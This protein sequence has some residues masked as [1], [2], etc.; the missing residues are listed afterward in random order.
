MTADLSILNHIRIATPCSA[1]WE[2]MAGDERTRFCGSC[3]KH[4]Y[5]IASMTAEEAASLIHAREGNL[6]ARLFQRADGTVMTSDCP[7]G[8]RGIWSGTQ[9]LAAAISVVAVLFMGAFLLPNVVRGDPDGGSGRGPI[10]QRATALW[11]DLLVWMGIRNRIPF[12]GSVCVLPP[13][14]AESSGQETQ[15]E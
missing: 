9:R 7:G 1:K 15:A 6:C 2:S 10:V 4:V 5:N 14:P 11:D 13:P 8:I 3:R 12:A